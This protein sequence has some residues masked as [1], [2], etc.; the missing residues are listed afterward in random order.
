M[1]LLEILRLVFEHLKSYGRCNRITVIRQ[2]D[3]NLFNMKLLELLA[4]STNVHKNFYV[5]NNVYPFHINVNKCEWIIIKVVANFMWS[6]LLK[7]V[8]SWNVAHLKSYCLWL[9]RQPSPSSLNWNSFFKTNFYLQLFSV[10][11]PFEL[12]LSSNAKWKEKV[13]KF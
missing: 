9:C 6:L 13:F 7:T 2:K 4:I 11:W 1:L 10:K 8:I 12:I 5:G 3:V